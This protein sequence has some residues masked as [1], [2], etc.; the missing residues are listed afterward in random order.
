MFT[1]IPMEHNHE[2]NEAIGLLKSGQAKI[3]W[4]RLQICSSSHREHKDESLRPNL[5]ACERRQL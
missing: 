1:G 5:K 3:L 4:E 2:S